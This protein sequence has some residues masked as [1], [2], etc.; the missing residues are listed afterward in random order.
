[1][2]VPLRRSIAVA[3]L[4]LAPVLT[5]CGFNE[6][7][8][9]VYT[10]GVGVNER[11]GQVDVLNALVVSGADGSGALVATLVNNDTGEAD[12]LTRVAGS[13]EDAAVRV[14]LDS[15]IEITRGGSV[16]VSDEAEVPVEGE[17]ITS[18]AFVQLTFTFEQAGPVTVQ[19]PVVA[20][21]GTYEDISVPS[22]APTTTAPEEEQESGH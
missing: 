18:G 9:R 16:S 14:S 2:N 11:S 13:G 21:R 7:T 22:V 17:P 20:R 8:D 6:P 12:A 5:S 10:P 1:M 15:P 3:A 19:V 4:A